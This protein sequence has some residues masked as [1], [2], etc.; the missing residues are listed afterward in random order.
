M[1]GKEGILLPSHPRRSLPPVHFLRAVWLE[2]DRVGGARSA[3]ALS[4]WMT[5]TLFPLLMCANC[6]IG[7][8]LPDLVQVLDELA[9]FLPAQTLGLLRD[10]LAYAAAARTPGLFL[11]SLTTILLSASAGLRTLLRTL[12]ELYRR[13][14]RHPLRRVVGSVLFS[15]LLLGAVYLSAVVLFTD[16]RL[17]AALDTHLPPPLAGLLPPGGLAALWLRLRYLLL[18]CV[19]FLLILLL[20]RTGTP[21]SAGT[22]PVSLSALAAALAL[23]VCSRLFSAFIG[24][25]ARYAL[26]YGSLAALILLQ[27]W[28]YV[29][30]SLLLLGAVMCRL[31]LLPAE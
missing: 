17:F 8:F 27:V 29:C 4:Y 15:A 19:L 24:R 12:D 9:P 5:L 20:Y 6:C 26:V 13:K 10:Y 18:L 11:A 1:G 31:W 7:L 23:V 2:Y 30:G 16:P 3:A 28:L 14:D 22:T 21:R 25:S